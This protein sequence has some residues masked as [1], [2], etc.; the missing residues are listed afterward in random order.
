MC[1]QC[2]I[3][4]SPSELCGRKP[5]IQGLWR[6]PELLVMW[7]G[8]QVPP[9]GFSSFDPEVALGGLP[10]ACA[11]TL[12]LHSSDSMRHSLGTEAS[13]FLVSLSYYL[14]FRTPRTR[15]GKL[16]VFDLSLDICMLSSRLYSYVKNACCNEFYS[17]EG[18]SWIWNMSVMF[19]LIG[20][21][22][23]YSK[24]FIKNEMETDCISAQKIGG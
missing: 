11:N 10:C 13:Y 22:L 4:G 1:S 9:A 16:V 3:E 20:L 6:Q 24:P 21:V 2:L 14:P 12:L 15:L 23:F 17:F 7:E 5:H 19:I 8:E 18:R